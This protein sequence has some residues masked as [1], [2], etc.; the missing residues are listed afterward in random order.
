MSL[1]AQDPSVPSDPSPP[2]GP[3][4]VLL[5]DHHKTLF[6]LVRDPR[7]EI[8]RAYDPERRPHLIVIAAPKLSAT[9]DAPIRGLPPEAFAGAGL[10]I[11]ATGKGAE[12]TPGFTGRLQEVLAERGL[13]EARCALV[14]NNRNAALPG[15]NVRIF[16]YDYW[17]RRM[18]NE[19]RKKGIAKFEL[20]LAHFRA[21]EACRP[22]RFLSFNMTAR[23]WKLMFLLSLLRDGLWDAG[24]ISFGGFAH[25]DRPMGETLEEV[26]AG[27]LKTDGFEDLAV[28][29]RRFLPALQA[30]GRVLFGEIPRTQEGVM[31]KATDGNRIEEFDLSWFSATT[32]TEMSGTKDYVTEKP[33]KALL[34]FQPQ[35]ILGNAGELRRLKA[36]GF[37][38]FRP[39]IDES[40]DREPDPRRRFDMAYAEIRRLCALS[41]AEMA[42]ME[43]ALADVLVA[44]ARKGL[45]D[46]PRRYREEWDPEIVTSLLALSPGATEL[47]I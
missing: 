28:E 40:Y 20:R 23:R 42:W 4:R 3:W 38:S 34:N 45:V 46:L 22:R 17:M 41:E 39:W 1:A 15:S 12:P 5:T 19:Y 11:D 10:V 13:T 47:P 25:V 2:P 9:F 35:V 31:R 8:Q 37:R 29:L 14:A 24:Y 43:Q 6:H 21:R 18:F 33:F 16:H 7:V 32:E 44:N 27:L 36:F 26:A 30:K